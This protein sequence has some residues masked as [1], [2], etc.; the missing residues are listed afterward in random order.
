MEQLL[1]KKSFRLSG[2]ALDKQEECPISGEYTL[3]EYCPDVAVVLKCFAYPRILN[4]QWSGDQ[5]LLDGNAVLR[6]LYLDEERRSVHSLEFTQSFSC[7]LRGEGKVDNAAVQLELGTKYLN[8]RAV[9][10]RRVEVRGAVTVTAYAECVLHKDLATTTENTALYTREV[11]QAITV[12]CSFADKVLTVSECV[13][14]PDTLPPAEMLL[15]GEC[16]AVIRD[17]KLLAGKAIVKG[18]VYFHQLY[19]TADE[20]VYSLDFAVPFSQILDVNDATEGMPYKATVQILSD[21]ERCIVGPDG[22]N[23]LFEICVK[24]LIQIW[25]YQQ[26]EITVI[27]EAYHSRY[28]ASAQ[29]EETETCCVIGTRWEE[30]VLPMQLTVP[31][32]RWQEIVDVCVQSPELTCTCNDGR[33]E[34]KGRLCVCVVARDM[35]GEIVYDEFLEDYSL[36]YVCE[37]NAT[38]L[39]VV[40]IGCKYRVIDNSLELQVSLCVTII[41]KQCERMNVLAD[42]RLQQD[43]PYPKQKA[44]AWLYYADAGESVWDIGRHCHTSSKGI[45]EENRL[46]DECVREPMVLVIPVTN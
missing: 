30:T 13:E 33:V 28:P 4:R 36:S 7:A 11:T 21:T 8:C 39:H 17:C 22:E 5:L 24:L 19:T 2:C 37:G 34:A 20:A 38:D 43:M 35:D 9:N 15:G 3:P 32:G 1:K 16:Q 10:P 40:P 6:V 46:E 45:C 29:M 14:F 18:N 27:K 25:L 23:S 44:T 41:D 31:S 42:L 26:E 12:P